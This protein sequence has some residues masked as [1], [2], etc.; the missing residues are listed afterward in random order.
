FKIIF[1][2]TESFSL[3]VGDIGILLCYPYGFS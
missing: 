3:G 1:P 2:T